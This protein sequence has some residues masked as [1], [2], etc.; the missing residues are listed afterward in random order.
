[1]L[2]VDVLPTLEGLAGVTSGHV[3]EGQSMFTSSLSE[4][5]IEHWIGNEGEVPTYCGVRSADWVYVKYG[6]G[7]PVVEGLYDE[8]TDPYEMTNLAVTD[9]SNPE[10]P[11]LRSDAENVCRESGGLYPPDW[12]F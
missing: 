10:L 7:E 11:L 3:I 5:V 9:P 12:P 2:N 4:F 8:A 1:V 6:D